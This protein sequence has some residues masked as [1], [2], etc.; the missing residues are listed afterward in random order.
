MTEDAGFGHNHPL[1][2]AAER[3]LAAMRDYKTGRAKEQAGRD[4]AI[5]AIVEYGKALSVGRDLCG[6][7]NNAFSDWIHRV[8]LDREKPFHDRQERSAAL[9]I[10][11][12]VAETVDGNGPVNP[13]TGCGCSRPTDIMGWWRLEQEEKALAGEELIGETAKAVVQGR[14]ARVAKRNA[15][16]ERSKG[17]AAN[18]D[19]AKSVAARAEKMNAFDREVWPDLTEAYAATISGRA[20][21]LR[22]AVITASPSSPALRRTSSQGSG[23]TPSRL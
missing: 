20:P 8:G 18:S 21:R 16:D 23:T 10:A 11:K 4:D 19:F 14:L 15:D 1:E 7:D 3:G 22:S 6:A 9:Q 17:I 2:I 5:A 13:F 12:I